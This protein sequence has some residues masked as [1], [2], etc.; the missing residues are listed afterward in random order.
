[1]KLFERYRN[2]IISVLAILLGLLGGAILML[3]NGNNPIE[4]YKNLFMGGLM[5][6]R[7]IGTSLAL[8]STLTLTGLS[9]A[10]AGRTGLFN[11]G[12][13]GQML[14]GGFLASAFALSFDFGRGLMIPLVIIV[15]VLGGA[16]WALV[17]GLLKARFNV[18]EVVSTIMMNWIAFWAVHYY[19]YNYFF[20]SESVK[21]S[22]RHIRASSSLRMAWL[23]ELFDGATINLGVIL[24]IVCVVLVAFILNKTVLG[25]EL[26]AVGF[27]RYSAEYAGISV[28]RSI[29]LSM[30]ISG[31]LAGLAGATY[32]C[33]YS[34]N[35]QA[36]LLPSQGYDGIAVALLGLNTPTG[37]ALAALFLGI[38]Q[39]GK[40]YMKAQANIEP[41]LA[42][43][44]VAIII[45]FAATSLMF[46]RVMD[47]FKKRRA[48]KA[49]PTI[50]IG[51]DDRLKGGM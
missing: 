13:P 32:Y 39:S 24:A 7:R 34:S 28:S 50:V 48:G 46:Q 29:I 33:G 2:A 23:S 26:K 37:S 44:I 9:L 41:E 6:M 16:L 19:V 4:G 20:E 27:N 3:V 8:A 22:T 17:P 1:M 10:F 21:T 30:L 36:G 25:F 45:Y 35:L 18:N 42:D 5:N 40:N 15:A 14:M 47:W 51:P 31:A 49:P 43:T 12:A 11:I 38:I